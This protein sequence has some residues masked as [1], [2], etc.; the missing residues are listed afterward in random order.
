MAR[1]SVRGG[2]GT[3]GTGALDSN[4]LPAFERVQC[5]DKDG[6]D[7][8]PKPLVA[9]RSYAAQEPA[10][11]DGASEMMRGDAAASGQPPSWIGEPPG[12]RAAADLCAAVGAAQPADQ[13]ERAQ[14]GK[15]QHSKATQCPPVA[16]ASRGVQALSWELRH[17][18]DAPAD[19]EAS[20]PVAAPAGSAEAAAAAAAAESDEA[21]LDML[22]PESERGDGG[23]S[24]DRASPTPSNGMQSLGSSRRGSVAGAVGE[25]G[26]GAVRAPTSPGSMRAFRQAAHPCL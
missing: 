17:A 19:A 11:G 26:C 25:A 10:W 18:G 24:R 21:L 13:L 5:I 14:P 8:T 23:G 12:M 3:R 15:R 7:R 2:G 9:A 22:Q 4:G 1:G 20:G 16:L 6:R